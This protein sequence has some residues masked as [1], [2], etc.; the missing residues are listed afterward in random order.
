MALRLSGLSSGM[1]TESIVSELMK[2]QN[3]KKTN[4][5]NKITTTEWVQDKWKALNSKIYSFYT[6]ELS[7]L[8]LQNSFNLKQASTSDDSRVSVNAS[9]NAAQGV[10]SIFINQLAKAQTLTGEKLNTDTNGKD[11]SLS[12]KLVDM[13]MD[14]GEDKTITITAGDKTKTIEINENTTIGEFVQTLKDAGLN[15]N[16]DTV[17]KRFFISSKNSGTENAFSMSASSG[18]DLAKLGLNQVQNVNGVVTE[19]GSANTALLQPVD[20]KVMYNGVE[21][22]S[23]SNTISANGITMTLKDLSIGAGT[24]SLSDDVPININIT[25]DTKGIYDMVKNFVKSYNEILSEITTNY[26]A[27][28]AKGFSPLTDEQKESMTDSQIEKWE[29]KIKDSLLRRDNNLS[30]IINSM[31]TSISDSVTVD[32]KNYSLASFG[33]SSVNYTEKG[34][35]HIKGD[36]DDKLTSG[37]ENELMKALTED[38]DT[39]M[40]V[41][42]GMADKLYSKLSTSMKSSSVRSA[43]TLYNDKEMT[44]QITDYKEGLKS[45]EAKLKIIESRYYKQFSAMESAMARLNSQSS[46][47][48]SML[49]QG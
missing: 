40:K 17:Q 33:I 4:I 28:S 41:L 44:K 36:A 45:L 14:A 29:S 39:V 1:D 25:S 49:G 13:G 20:A 7:K 2:A 43:L 37:M 24:A 6:G 47:L 42:N 23:S 19:I 18:V 30:S 5:Q 22:T 16:Y 27:P 15:A 34:V 35:L 31:R 9:A 38:P 32:G 8:R 21:L 3:L 48:A 26:E 10:H 11:I 12:T 46:S